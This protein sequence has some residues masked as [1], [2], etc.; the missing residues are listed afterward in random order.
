MLI[1]ITLTTNICLLDPLDTTTLTHIAFMEGRNEAL[2]L[3]LK[4]RQKEKLIPTGTITTTIHTI[5]DTTT[6]H[7]T[8][9]ENKQ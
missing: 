5:T 1:Y 7:T 4:Q 6:I 2:N 9:M 3:N 8:G